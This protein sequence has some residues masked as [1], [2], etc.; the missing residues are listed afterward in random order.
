MTIKKGLDFVGITIVFLCHDGQGNI[1]LNKRSQNCRDEH[2]CWDPGAGALEHGHTVI[3]TLKKEIK[4]EYCTEIISKRFLGYSE[5]HRSHQNQPTHWIALEFL[6]Q[7]D[8][9]KVKNG[10]PNKFED[11][12]WFTLDT[13]PKP[14]HSHFPKFLKKYSK[15]LKKYI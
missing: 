5:L 2:G 9:S 6:V 13:F 4:E 7:V 8:R 15:Q 10:E 11:L 14:L 3:Q 1:L 12:Q